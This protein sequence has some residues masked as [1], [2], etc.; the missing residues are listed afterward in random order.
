MAVEVRTYHIDVHHSPKHT[1]YLILDVGKIT[2]AVRL[3]VRA[4]SKFGSVEC[5]FPKWSGYVQLTSIGKFIFV[6]GSYLATVS[7]REIYHSRDCQP[8]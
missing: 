2:Y 1:E 3:R 7:I 6:Q 5:V 8:G 4:C